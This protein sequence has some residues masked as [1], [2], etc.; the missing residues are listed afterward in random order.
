[1]T[2]QSSG[3][4]DY[5][6]LEK[7]TNLGLA[8]NIYKIQRELKINNKYI[9]KSGN[10]FFFQIPSKNYKFFLTNNTILDQEFLDKEKKN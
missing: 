6:A 3:A 2:Y 4:I 1:M 7:I 9:Y 10:G 5:Q 8:D